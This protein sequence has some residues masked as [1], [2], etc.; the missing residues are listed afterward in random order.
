MSDS[1]A[2]RIVVIVNH[3]GIH[4][5]PADLFVRRANE[6]QSSV[7][8]FKGNERCDGKSVLSMLTL[9]A[10]QGTE[11]TLR[12][13]GPDADSALSALAELVAQGFGEME[14]AAPGP[15]QT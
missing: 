7:E 10:V 13:T 14:V 15:K 3:L 9:A 2:A 8:V 11:L 1:V 12:A 4:L 6:F 5:R